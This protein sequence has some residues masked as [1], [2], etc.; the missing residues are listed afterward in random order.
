[1]SQS[2]DERVVEMRFN[3][4]RF[5]EGVRT[6]MGTIARLKQALK[7]DGACKGF[8]DINK[9]A[10]KG[11]SLE[12]IASGVDSLQKRFSTF[13]IV[14]MRVIQNLTDAS[15]KF[16]KSTVGFVSDSII[17]GGKRRAANIENAHF[18]LQGLLKDEEKVQAV[19]S[20]AMDS[21]DGTA[22]AYDEAAKA[23]SQF[24]AS[25]IEAGEK[26]QSSLR[27]ITGV[28]AMTNSEYE[29]ISQI[30]TTVAGNGRLMGD[31]LLQLSSRGLNAAATLADYMTKVGNGAKVTETEVR[32]MVSK[33]EISFE[34]FAAAMDD[35]FGEHAKRANETFTGAMSNVKASLARIGAEFVS[36]LIVQNGPLVE[37]LNTLRER[38]ND[39]KANIGPLA[40]LFVDSITSM[41]NVATNFLKKLDVKGSLKKFE[42][43]ASPWD[44]LSEKITSAGISTD[45][46]QEK[47]KET[48][49]EHG[50][51]LDKLIKEYGSLGKVFSAGKISGNIIVE[52][53][54]KFSVVEP[55]VSKASKAVQEVTD[56]TKEYGEVVARVLKGEFGNGQARIEALT[57]AG[58]DYVVVQNLVN[59]NL[60]SSVRHMS[61]LTDEQKKNAEQL[62]ELSDIQLENQ[63]YT[64]EQIEAMRDLAAQAEKAG[65]PLNELI[66]SMEKPSGRELLIDSFRN[67]LSG[68]GKILSSVKNAW[69]E[70]FPPKTS[71]QLYGTIE[72]LNSFSRCLAMTDETADKLKRSFKGLFALLSIISTI[73]GG[74]LRIGLKML[75]LILNLLDVDILSVTASVGDSIVAFRDWLKEHNLVTKSLEKLISWLKNGIIYARN[76]I[77]EFEALPNVRK[78][79]GQLQN[80][81]ADVL[82]G[83]PGY[84]GE[85][86]KIINGFIGR[87]MAM[88]SL[89]LDNLKI[90]FLD[91][92]KNVLGYF[93]NGDGLFDGFTEALKNTKNDVKKYFDETVS[94]FTEFRTKV[95]SILV[96]LKNMIGDNFGAIA[97]IALGFGLLVTL[98]KISDALKE[99]STPIKAFTE[100]I[101]GMTNVLKACSQKIK[102]EAVYKIAKSIAVLAGSVALLSMLD[103]EKAWSA[104]KMLGAMAA[105]LLVFSALLGKTGKVGKVSSSVVGIAGAVF[106]LVQALKSMESL[107]SELIGR[108]LAILGV[109]ALGM[110]VFAAILSKVAPRLSKGSLFLLSFASSLKIMVSALEELS[111]LKLNRP[112]ETIGLLLGM[113][114]GLAIVAAACK[115]VKIGAAVTILGIAVSL[116]I[117]IG[118][119]EKIAS[120]KPDEMRSRMEAF[121]KIFG[122]FTLLMV[123]SRMAGKNA[124]KAGV[125]ILAMSGALIIIVHAIK[126]MSK[127]SQF[128]LNRGLE[129]IEELLLVFS[130]VMVLSKFAGKNATKAGAMLLLMSGAILILSRVIWILSK[131]EPEGLDRALGA[132]VTLE[133]VFGTL[134][135]VTKLAKDCKSTLIVLSATIAIL[136]IA[137]GSLSLIDPEKLKAASAALSMVM[138]M[139]AIM[140]AVTSKAKKATG[141]LVTLT[142]VVGALGGIL[143]LLAGLPTESAIGAAEG[144]SI[145]LLALSASMV[146]I[147]KSGKIGPSAYVTLGV[148]T[149][150]V[151]GLA[152]IIGLLA[153]MHVGPVLEISASLSILLL[154]LSGACLILSGVGLVGAAA[155]VGVGALVTLIGAVGGVMAAIGALVTYVPE[156]EQWLDAGLPVLE[157]I[158]YGL[159]AFFGNIIGGFSSGIMAGLPKIGENLS[160]FMESMAPFFEGVKAIDV[161]GMSGVKSLAETVL[162]LTATDLING[163]TAWLTGG[164]SLARFALQ[165]APLGKGIAE[166]SK[167]VKDV[168]ANAVTSAASAGKAVA[169]L[170]KA[171]PNSGGVAGFFAGNNDM[172]KF[173]TGLTTFGDSLSTYYESVSGVNVSK[174]NGVTG[175]IGNL[176]EVIKNMSGIDSSSISGFT[177]GLSDLGEGSLTTLV[178]KFASSD[179]NAKVTETISSMMNGVV[180]SIKGKENTVKS[181]VSSIVDG[182]ISGMRGKYNDFYSTGSYLVDG[183]TKGISDNAFKAAAQAR[184]M[185]SAAN[186]AARNELGV[187]SPST[188]FAEIG[189]YVVE[190]FANGI[191]RN[192]GKASAATGELAKIGTDAAR[193]VAESLKDSNSV[194]SDYAEK[195]DDNGNA[196]EVTLESAAK[197]FRSFRDSIKESIEGATG[198]FDEFK[199]ETDVTGK[200]LLKNLQSQITG[201]TEWASNIQTLAGRGISEGLLKALS[202][203]GPSGAKY[204]STLVTMTDAELKKLNGLYAQRISLNG[205]A[206]NEIAASFLNGG[207]KINNVV[208]A[209]LKRTAEAFNTLRDSIKE[210]IEGA[211]G[212]FDEFKEETDVTGK[213]LLKNL[214]SQITGITEWAS[215]IQI[216]ADRGINKGL[217]KVLSDMGP[218][219]AKYVSALVTMS[220]KELKKLNKLYTQRLSLN[221]KAA[222]E[223][224]G[225]FVDGGKKAAQAYANGVSAAAQETQT[226][227]GKAGNAV[228]KKMVQGSVSAVDKMRDTLKSKVKRTYQDAI[229]EAKSSLDY[230]TGAFQQFV[231]NYLSVA[232]NITTGNKAIKAASKAITAYGK[233][234]YEES[235]YYKEDTANLKSHKKELSALQN[236][237]KNLQKQLK[238]AQK[239]NT[240]ASRARVKTLKKEL[241]ANGKAI[242]AAKE[243]IKEDEKEIANHTKEVFNNLRSTLT[244]SV[245]SFLDPL[246]L[247]LESGVDLF[248]KFESNTDLYEADKKNLEEHKKSLSE[249]ED[250]QR[251]IQDE[252]SKYADKN[253]LAARKRVKELK[254]QLSEVESSIEEAKQKIEQDENDMA[255]HSEVT[256]NSILENMQSQV[257]G[258]TRWQQ[259]LQTLAGRGLSEGLL[260]KLKEMGTDGV[261][262]VE[263]FMKMTASELSQANSLFAQSENLTSQTLLNN[264]KDSLNTA[265][266][267]AS[268]LQQMVQMGFSQNLLEKLGDMGVDGYDYVKA[269]LSM[270]PAQVAQFNQEF[271]DSLSL[272]DTIADQVISSYAYAGAQSVEG[273][274]SALARLSESDSEENLELVTAVKGI[275]KEMEKV[276]KPASKK[277]GA[278]SAKALAKGIDSKKDMAK[279]SS[280]ELGN[281]AL[282]SLK[283]VLSSENGKDVGNNVITGI[284]NGLLDGKSGVTAMAKKVAQESYNAAKETLGIHSP[285]RK[286]A[287]LGRYVD[288]GFAKGLASGEKDI[289]QKATDV[290]GRAIQKVSDIANS[291]VENQ[292]KICPVLDLS[293]IQNGVHGISKMMSGYTVAAS[294]NLA[295]VTAKSMGAVTTQND[296]ITLDAIKKLQDTLSEFMERPGIEQ[297]NTFSIT[298]SDPRE[299][300]DEVSH[301]LQQQIERKGATWA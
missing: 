237:R 67:G 85:G 245:S 160:A 6:T 243:Q 182:A 257:A 298:G 261:D 286:F 181:A 87:T 299:I 26:M 166:F 29:G 120:L 140:T 241:E 31:Q 165:L 234:L 222:E 37:F 266:N 82:G 35:A 137:L 204:A 247:S 212:V 154:A 101:D 229:N 219:G 273:F 70:V 56:H 253:T 225:S 74:A 115:N 176:I 7:F 83:L 226:E 184:A 25:G 130:G 275:G 40:D 32:D 262:Y 251:K 64:V 285:S 171:L 13:G 162:I 57:K 190:G 268:G 103:Q 196:V 139:F 149:L 227:T 174:L 10:K 289:C 197:A 66:A 296:D 295:E 113:V 284:K 142:L 60:D 202:D 228:G 200:Q 168:D 92:R 22:Y 78:N 20:D 44:K 203:M 242:S 177:K 106:I 116:H 201:I 187:H 161:Q 221:D 280:R 270:T 100:M 127:I 164:N 3:N 269:F 69:S 159:G 276:L 279:S 240:A 132:I 199:E 9:T 21:V 185:A 24:A 158:G 300:A 232:K 84:F 109:L 16:A 265:K 152:A 274:V 17:N 86:M 63:G 281:A 54:K 126:M 15:M 192:N 250:T 191:H 98:K 150:V 147:G 145:L 236:E 175:G 114:T 71:E 170:G 258:V 91:F 267:W 172:G 76:W 111:K 188:I 79:L 216:L 288:E 81:F 209:T 133:V 52:T 38:I 157:K 34:L 112:G 128:D 4:K 141:A 124:A 135:A 33:G 293:E 94:G 239:S 65:T 68:L 206:A 51:S 59:E 1:M 36:P 249:L 8:D 214:Q 134:I 156:V 208:N 211:T 167:E 47:L 195:T 220:S 193:E 213:Q 43:F 12:A 256:V 301:I 58:Y 129:V 96:G 189:G 248:K 143:Y 136:A 194:F 61:D 88:D 264:F 282:K 238:K 14:G 278:N 138:V 233:K 230:G 49:A 53:L 259:N 121:I 231:N 151:G 294:M 183:F 205:K 179:G 42:A 180:N 90:A 46:F 62:S 123:A 50:I 72:G 41:A 95:E 131:V 99:I 155:F 207:K 297:H 55:T 271:T 148:M 217:L 252:I 277:T 30:F 283:K 97:T 291:D 93:L 5:E 163:M 89:T 169:E 218:S 80:A 263:Q 77:G 210:S 178:Q 28:A 235:D 144:L 45:D 186:E 292:P 110:T 290:M 108:D 272:P 39:V 255:S 19:M 48:S 118:A 27:A 224:A 146:I 75:S 18:Q 2:V 244:E 23:A 107:D 198:V 153:S 122:M 117:L 223:I 173:G 105:G 215:N 73:T 260:S 119:L 246:R 102:A 104:I 11:V 125:G 254:S 287:E